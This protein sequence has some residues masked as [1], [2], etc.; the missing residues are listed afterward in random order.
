MD[1]KYD[2]QEQ[3]HMEMRNIIDEARVVLPGGQA[4]FGF[5]TIAVF[6]DCFEE[7]VYYAKACHALGMILV[8]ISI[9]MVMTPATYYRTVH[10]HA[11]DAMVK[12]SSKMIRGP[13][14]PLAAG[15][16]LDM[17]TVIHVVSTDI[18]AQLA[19]STSAGLGT[20]LLLFGLWYVT[21]HHARQSKGGKPNRG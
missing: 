20:L 3:H 9:A 12:L 16:A 4:L 8:V 17:F 21:P 13:L 2:V 10:R 6:N 1:K 7:L 19:S 5:Q 11:T 18:P 14:A 15:L